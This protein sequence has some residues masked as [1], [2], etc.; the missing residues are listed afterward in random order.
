M[1]QD[2]FVDGAEA[3]LPQLAATLRYGTVVKAVG[4]LNQIIVGDTGEAYPRTHA[5][6]FPP[7]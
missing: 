6:T 5:L 1:V 7:L 3:A 4:D 2:A